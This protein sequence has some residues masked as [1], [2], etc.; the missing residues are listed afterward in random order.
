MVM[1]SWDD[2]LSWLDPLGHFPATS[3]SQT[4]WQG[5]QGIHGMLEP[6][7]G[8]FGDYRNPDCKAR[9]IVFAVR[10]LGN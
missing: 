1:A 6:F 3:I 2:L 9:R 10:L 8:G 7:M 4:T 5:D